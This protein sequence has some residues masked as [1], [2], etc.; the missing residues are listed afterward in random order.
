MKMHEAI[1][2]LLLSKNKEMWIRPVCWFGWEQ[3]YCLDRFST[4]LEFV[5]GRGGG[6]AWMTYTIRHLVDDWE[7]VSPDVVLKGE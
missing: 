5:P 4:E 3:A 6:E 7:V 1:E 2:A